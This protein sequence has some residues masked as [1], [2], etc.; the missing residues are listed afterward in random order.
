MDNVRRFEMVGTYDVKE[1]L[2]G[3]FDRQVQ[4]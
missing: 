1:P 3:H 2:L 4:P